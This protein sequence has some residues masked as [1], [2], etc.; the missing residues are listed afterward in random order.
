MT[1]AEART[2]VQYL[3]AAYSRTDVIDNETT[4]AVWTEQL[5]GF[6]GQAA[7]LAAQR[8]IREDERFPSIHRVIEA[9][10]QAA[11]DIAR[12]EAERNALGPGEMSKCPECDGSEWVTTDTD[13]RGTVRPCSRCNSDGYRLWAEGHWSPNHDCPDCRERRRPKRRSKAPAE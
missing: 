3:A 9:S 12:D 13:G 8:I 2:I 10:Q 4:V 6:S 5:R 1:P 7:H 11:R